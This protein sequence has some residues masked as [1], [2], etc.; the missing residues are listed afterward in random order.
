MKRWRSNLVRCV[1]GLA[2]ML[3]SLAD[4]R[5]LP[6]V[7]AITPPDCLR[8]G[9]EWTVHGAGFGA[10]P[11]G[12]RVVLWDGM[13]AIEM[14]VVWW[15]DNQI[16]LLLPRDRRLVS[17]RVFQVWIENR[18]R[19]RLSN[20]G[21]IVRVCDEP[22][23]GDVDDRSRHLA[24]AVVE[25]HGGAEWRRLRRLQFTTQ[26]SRGDQLLRQCRYDWDLR[27]NVVQVQ[28]GAEDVV[29]LTLRQA[30]RDAP[31]RR[32][33]TVWQTDSQQWL[34]PLRLLEPGVR[35][36]HAGTRVVDGRPYEV[37]RVGFA[38]DVLDQ[39]VY[40]LLIEPRSYRVA[41]SAVL[42]DAQPAAVVVWD[43]YKRIG[44]CWLATEFRS[45][46]QRIRYTDTR[47]E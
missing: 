20:P 18:Q 21:I 42:T 43:R 32:A 19:E 4:A 35:V 27:R 45:G 26:T 36:Q 41:Y 6:I 30:P 29:T 47:V 28:C 40:E 1:V 34:L 10:A 17:G 3:P 15:Q 33:W 16:R 44:P 12:R 2:T 39:N 14:P 23:K 37:L 5:G 8:L 24:A 7:Q 46:D 9:E 38:P 31:A 13:Q 25:A 11:E 22:R